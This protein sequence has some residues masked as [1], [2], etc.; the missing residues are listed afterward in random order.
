[1]S[2]GDLVLGDDD[3][4]VVAQ[5][6]LEEELGRPQAKDRGEAEAMARS[7]AAELAIDLLGFRKILED[8]A[9]HIWKL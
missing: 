4:A 5:D 3:G 7:G 8:S 2:P 6:R 9:I 1:M